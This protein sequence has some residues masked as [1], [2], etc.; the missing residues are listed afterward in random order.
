M[1]DRTR[2]LKLMPGLHSG[3]TPHLQRREYYISTYYEVLLL[4]VFLTFD[5]HPFDLAYL[6]AL[7]SD[8]ALKLL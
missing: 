8:A 2:T 6:L 4:L 7:R 1:S 5:C 3:L